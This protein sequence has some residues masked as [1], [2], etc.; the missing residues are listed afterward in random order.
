MTFI[1][2]GQVCLT[3]TSDD[4]NP[5]G[6]HLQSYTRVDKAAFL[7]LSSNPT[8]LMISFITLSKSKDIGDMNFGLNYTKSTSLST[9]SVPESSSALIT[10]ISV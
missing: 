7:I 4:L 3:N 5:T 2:N 6:L 9:N 10:L 8:F 1:S